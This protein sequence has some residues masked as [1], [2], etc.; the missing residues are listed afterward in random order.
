MR[1]K[2]VNLWEQ[3]NWED[4]VRR[5][6]SSIDSVAK[7]V[8]RIISEIKKNGDRAL[9]KFTRRFDGIN[10]KREDLAVTEDEI[11]KA[12]AEI[13]GRTKRAIKRAAKSIERFHR[14][15]L[16]EGWFSKI[17]QGISAGVLV[18]PL[19]SVG[20]YVPG[21]L[22]RY[23]STV[24]M[25]AVP[26]RVAG[27]EKVVVCTP[28]GKNGGVDPLT[29]YA[30]LE[31]GV[32]GI[33]KVGGAQA[34]AAMAYG[35]ETIPKVD[36]I[37]GP[38][39]KYVSAAKYIVS[40]DVGIEFIAGPSEILIIADK[41][42][43]AEFV[44]ADML[45]QAEHD[46]EAAAVLV[47]TSD[48]L[49]HEVVELLND[50][51]PLCERKET[52]SKSLE[53]NGLIAV[54]KDMEQAAEFANEYAPEHLEIITRDP[55]RVLPMIKNAG[56]IFIGPYSPVAAGDFI[57]GPNHILPTGGLARC[58][59]GLSV[60]DFVRLPTVQEIS[61]EALKRLSGDIQAIALSEGLP[62]HA[63]SVRIRVVDKNG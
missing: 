8:A 32:K 40:K 41:S 35:T 3:K 27:V 16:P 5:S 23:P 10:L 12:V 22:A 24:L 2:K 15:N 59:S 46:P 48:A 57:T 63:K 51:L 11:K 61:R 30:A 18:R 58:R 53:K 7:N 4:L 39:N 62:Q 6:E 54:A 19:E 9:I 25:A 28:P 56:S 38:G 21:G 26:A 49:S 13:D 20:V 36:K 52:I 33:F 60:L 14:K 44:A 29:I 42:A 47:T 50:L 31:S 37:V 1:I 17:S 55:R 34:I 45:A 43:D